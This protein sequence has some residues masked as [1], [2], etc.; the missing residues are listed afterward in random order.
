MIVAILGKGGVGK[1]TITALLLRHLLDRRQTP[2]LA[3]DADPSSCLGS[4]LGLE[5]MATLGAVREE[6]RREESRPASIAKA[7][8]LALQAEEALV[9]GQGYDLLT[10]G[11]GEGRGCYC[12]VNNLIREHVDRLSRHYRHV[13]V[14]CE[15]GVEHLSR[16]TAGRPDAVVCV[17]NRSRM[18]AETVSRALAVY[19]E[20]HGEPPPRLDLVLNGFTAGETLAEDVVRGFDGTRFDS[21][22]HVPA[23]EAL[24]A[25]EAAGRSILELAPT[26]P[27][28]RALSSWEI[29]S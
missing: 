1:T 19:R 8:W 9:E 25:F 6:L 17:T 10:M 20:V 7:D 26:S 15:A 11:R 21:V 24:P 5:I 4:V 16:R 14:D 18:G 2:I 12:F 29:G 3:V 22:L 27:A 13:L 28:L 23:D